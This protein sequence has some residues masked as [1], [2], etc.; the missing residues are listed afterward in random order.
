MSDEEGLNNRYILFLGCYSHLART[1][2]KSEQLFPDLVT[3]FKFCQ[4]GAKKEKEKKNCSPNKHGKM[5]VQTPQH[6]S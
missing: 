1:G 6:F 2:R 3:A 5:K 4:L